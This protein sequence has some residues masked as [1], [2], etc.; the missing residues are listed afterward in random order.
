M[1][2]K[3]VLLVSVLALLAAQAGFA[4]SIKGKVSPGKSVVYLEST[5][6]VRG[7]PD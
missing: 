7:T 1:K 4:G 6:P 5:A 3:Y 2:M